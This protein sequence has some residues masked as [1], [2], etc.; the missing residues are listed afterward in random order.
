MK[1]IS[2]VWI[3]GIILFL[4]LTGAFAQDIPVQKASVIPP[5]PLEITYNKTTNLIFPYAIKSVDKGS[6]DVLAQKAIGVENVLQLK[7]AKQGFAQSNLTVITADGSFYPYI[8]DYSD[9]PANLNMWIINP[10]VTPQPV[11][12][13]SAN[14]TNNVIAADAQKIISRDRIIKGLI[15]ADYNIVLDVK[16]VYSHDDVL[17]FQ[18][19]LQNHSSIDYTIQSLRFFIHDKKR[20]KRTA[21]QEIEMTP[22]YTLGNIGGIPHASE[23]TIC[24]ALSRFTI[25]DKKYLSLQLME[26]NGGRHLSVKIKNKTLMRSATLL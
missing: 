16:G 1:K 23:Q 18:V 11:A 12:V 21:E 9:E 25:P 17:Y 14:A 15:D 7:A 26:Q 19:S 2:A 6:A 13:F 10:Q 20:I 24:I 8:L 22:L 4:S 3:T 5:Y